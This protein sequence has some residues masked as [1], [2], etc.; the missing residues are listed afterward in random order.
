MF[1]KKIWAIL[2][3]VM[4]IGLIGSYA[5]Y[6]HQRYKHLAVHEEGM[7]YRSAWVEPD[8][9]SELIE[10]YQFRTVVNLCKPGEMGEDRWEK[11][12]EAGPTTLL[13]D[14]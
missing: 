2:I 10:T 11:Q 5:Y 1:R 6:H 7:M 4:F 12:R 8:V 3:V 14:R 13:G 9:F